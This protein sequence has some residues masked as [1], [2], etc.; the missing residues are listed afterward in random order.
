MIGENLHL[1]IVL[2]CN[3]LVSR[4]AKHIA[5][6]HRISIFSFLNDIHILYPIFTLGFYF[7]AV[8]FSHYKNNIYATEHPYFHATRDNNFNI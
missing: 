3:S 7:I 4:K 5:M 2:I 6:L 1:R 8:I